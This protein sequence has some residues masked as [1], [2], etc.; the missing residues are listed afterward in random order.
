MARE[1]DDLHKRIQQLPRVLALMDR[2]A[3]YP[4]AEACEKLL[5]ACIA[6]R[7]IG[8]AAEAPAARASLL[9]PRGSVLAAPPS[10]HPRSTAFAAPP[11]P[12]PRR[13]AR[14]GR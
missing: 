2:H 9:C 4:R 3:V 12:P 10:L 13:T 7:E 11:R 8:L 1:G 14:T 6:T 5:S